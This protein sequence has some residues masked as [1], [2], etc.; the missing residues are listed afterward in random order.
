MIPA[1]NEHENIANCLEGLQNQTRRPD[2]VIVVD[3]ESEDD[4]AEIAR[5]L[6][7]KVLSF[8]R[9]DI[10]FGNVGLVRQ[11]GVES[12][13]GDVVISTDADFTHP[14]D[15][16]QK[17]EDR[18]SANSNLAGLG[19]PVL[20]SNPDPW[21]TFLFNVANLHHDYLAGWG[22]PVFWGGNTS[23]RKDAFMRAG[24]Y[25][26]AAGHGPVE[27][28]IV[29]FRLTRV[30]DVVWDSDLYSFTKMSEHNRAYMYALPLS[31]TPLG[32]FGLA[33]VLFGVI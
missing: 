23:F 28:W 7:A 18:F 22:V 2:E 30:G 27:E 4:T 21:T 32:V 25:K 12:A 10:Y 5:S 17:V 8:P 20:I 19:G 24:G 9:P 3:N 33:S 1:L 29:S 16:V 26:G 13:V 31:V 6:G 14:A 15:Y 11:K